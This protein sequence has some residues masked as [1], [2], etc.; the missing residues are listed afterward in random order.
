MEAPLSAIARRAGVGQGSL[1]RHFPTRQSLA[2][3]VFD[4]NMVQ[5][6][7]LAA[8]PD[9]TLRA[10]VEATWD[11]PIADGTVGPEVTVDQF[12]FAISVIAPA[13]PRAAPGQRHDY[14]A[15]VWELLTPWLRGRSITAPHA[16][17]R[18]AH[19]R[20]NGVLWVNV[21]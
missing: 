13:V 16:E 9:T 21:W 18:P 3:A 19:L 1:Y 14:A 12:M 2:L 11:A 8:Q 7:H 6:E 5:L 17:R 15:Q 4:Q 10:A 20:P